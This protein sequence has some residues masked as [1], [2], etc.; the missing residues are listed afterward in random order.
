MNFK[1]KDGIT[2]EDLINTKWDQ[3]AYTEE[4]KIFWQ[5]TMFELGFGWGFSTDNVCSSTGTICYGYME[6]I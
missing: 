6:E 2:K 5:E 1:L 4:Q 3:S